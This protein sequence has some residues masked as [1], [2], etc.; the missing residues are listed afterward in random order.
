MKKLFNQDF[1]KSGVDYIFSYNLL[2]M[3]ENLRPEDK[4]MFEFLK[5]YDGTVVYPFDVDDR[6]YG[7]AE[8]CGFIVRPQWCYPEKVNSGRR[9]KSSKFYSRRHDPI[10]R[11]RL[12]TQ[13]R[14]SRSCSNL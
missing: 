13:P 1:N 6:L 10:Y 7:R 12:R 3:S 5:E 14:P 11:K 8:L 4:D 2:L 9:P